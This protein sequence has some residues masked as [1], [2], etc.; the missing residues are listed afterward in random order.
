[1]G[2]ASEISEYRAPEHNN[3]S[4]KPTY[5]YFLPTVLVAVYYAPP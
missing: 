2:Q 4:K 5:A 1:M 3:T